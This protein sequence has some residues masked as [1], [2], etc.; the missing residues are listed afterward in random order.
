MKTALVLTVIVSMAVVAFTTVPADAQKHHT[1]LDYPSLGDIEI[2]EVKQVTL[3]NGLNLFLLEDHE[4]PLVSLSA[5]IR[6]GASFEPAD[7]IGLASITGTVMRTGGTASRSGDDLDEELEFIAASVETSI[8]SDSGS[9][10]MSVL[11]EDVDRGLEI[12]ADIIMN[13]AFPEDK[14]ELARVK[15]RSAIARRNDRAGSMASREYRKLIY[16]ADSVHARHT[17]YETINRITRADLVDFH[18]QFFCPN[19]TMMAV[20]GD[21]E[22]SDMID[23]IEHAFEE[24][25]RKEVPLP[26]IPAV[27]YR[28]RSTVNQVVK[29]DVNQA[30]IILGHIGGVRNDPDYF[31]LILMNR[32]LGRGFTS[33]LFRRVRSD[34]GLAYSVHGGYSSEFDHPGIFRVT[35]STGSGNTVKAIRSMM[36]EVQRMT[37]A[38]VTDDE[39]AI[40]R[41]AFLNS[42]VFK[43][44][45]KGKVVKRLIQYAYYGYSLDFLQQIKKNVERVT[46]ADI[47]R[48]AKKHLHPEAMQIIVVGKP[49]DFDKPLSVLGP[50]NE[51]DVSIPGTGSEPGEK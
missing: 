50:V 48:V 24:W 47:L 12:L 14:I 17:E 45:S 49:Q 36:H 9:A 8:G 5:V 37:E 35:C 7:K 19:N 10:S 13:P 40:A 21:F 3:P 1:D 20:W 29:N 22:T 41:E 4:L 26:V 2:P 33:R 38:E 44:D 25:K 27:E 28:Y 30:N 31:A 16:G 43:F 46:K 15:A 42:F 51:I 32:I 34:Q 23:R 6:V 11:K 39:L 18:R